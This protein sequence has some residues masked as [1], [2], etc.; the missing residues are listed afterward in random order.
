MSHVDPRI[1]CAAEVC[2]APVT[3]G[4]G[5]DGLVVK[6][7]SDSLQAAVGIL[8]DAGV[9]E[10]LAPKVARQLHGMGVAL[11]STEL[12]EAIRHIAFPE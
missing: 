7:S 9:P 4:T 2:C 3:T 12:A 6:R 11:L 8:C 5:P 1:N 10:D